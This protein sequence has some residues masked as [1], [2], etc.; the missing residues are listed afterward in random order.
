MIHTNAISPEKAK[1]VRFLVVQES[2]WDLAVERV[3][4]GDP[5]FRF[6]K[7]DT[8]HL[9]DNCLLS[10]TGEQMFGRSCYTLDTLHVEGVGEF[11]PRSKLFQFT[12]N[13]FDYHLK[14][15]RLKP[16]VWPILIPVEFIT[17]DDPRS[18]FHEEKN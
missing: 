13:R 12:A 8:D 15:G 2:Q 17:P 7:V 11:A 18:F 9:C 4:D 14:K 5:D 10:I 6:D 1:E 16:V 3:V